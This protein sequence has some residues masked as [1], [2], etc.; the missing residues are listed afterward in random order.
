[1]NVAVILLAA[2]GSTRLGSPKQ[3]LIYEGKTLLRRAAEAARAVAPGPVVI[4]LG[5]GAERHREELSGLD[6]VVVENPAWEKGMG[7]SVRG[8]MEALLDFE[9]RGGSGEGVL[10]TLCDQPLVGA[11]ALRK[12]TAAAEGCA[13]EIIVAASYDGTVGVPVWFGRAYFEELRCLPE[14]EGAKRLLRR[15]AARVVAVA[16]P[17]AAVDIDTREQYERLSVDHVVE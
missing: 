15:H 14:E 6:V 10:L 13:G 4:V 7:S 8:G 1:M 17:E 12:I 2:G 11:E 5:A 16:L 9:R 3:L